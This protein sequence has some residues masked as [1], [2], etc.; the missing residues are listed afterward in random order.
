MS[1]INEIY[2]KIE[3]E[4]EACVEKQYSFWK[5]KPRHKLKPICYEEAYNRHAAELG[6]EQAQNAGIEDLLNAKT[7]LA[8]QAQNPMMTIGILVA[9]ILILYILFK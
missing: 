1:Q 8:S 9:A 3:T 6:E 4:T 5:F 2:R 7:I